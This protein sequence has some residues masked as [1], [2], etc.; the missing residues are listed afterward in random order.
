MMKRH[1]PSAI[2]FES[3]KKQ[4]I[5]PKKQKP[6]ADNELGSDDE[7]SGSGFPFNLP[8][9]FK[10]DDELVY[11]TGNHIYFHTDVS[12]KSID[13]VKKLMR[14]YLSKYNKINKQHTCGTFT[15]KP[16]ILHIYSPGGDVYAGLSLYDFI[17]SYNNTIPVYTHVDGLAASAATIISLAGS[18]RFIGPNSYMLI[19]QL[20]TFLGGNFEQIKDEFDNCQ[21]LMNKLKKIYSERTTIPKKQLA[22]ILKHDITWDADECKKYGLIDEIKLIDLFNDCDI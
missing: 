7:D 22:D 10:H 4:K 14:E 18:K 20:S 16:L 13:Q 15:P 12:E 8:S 6:E 17:V 21:K 11:I 19:H 3:S 1:L 5:N 9:L 2:Y